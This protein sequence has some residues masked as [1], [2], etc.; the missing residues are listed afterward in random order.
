MFFSAGQCSMAHSLVNQDVDEGPPDQD[1]V[2][3]SP[4]SRPEP[5]WKPLFCTWET[6]GEHGRMHESCDWQLGHNLYIWS[7]M[8]LSVFF[9]LPVKRRCCVTLCPKK[10]PV[11]VEAADWVKS[12]RLLIGGI[13]LTGTFKSGACSRPHVSL[14]LFYIPCLISWQLWNWCSLWLRQRFWISFVHIVNI[15][16]NKC[17]SV[18][19]ILFSPV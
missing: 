18:I 10:V 15:L 16:S 12:W 4:T 2:M 1:P 6:G 11:Q 3:A 14:S 9:S 17:N 7:C 13:H 5:H 19:S 8:Y